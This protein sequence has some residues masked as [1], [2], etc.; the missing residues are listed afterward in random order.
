MAGEKL[1]RMKLEFVPIPKLYLLRIMEGQSMKGGDICD[2]DALSWWDERPE[3]IT[4]DGAIRYKYYD[5]YYYLYLPD[6]ENRFP[7]EF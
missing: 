1:L 2:V 5:E 6:V 4:Y 7:N 3:E